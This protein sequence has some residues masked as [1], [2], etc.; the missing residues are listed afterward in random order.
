[1]DTISDD[2]YDTVARFTCFCFLIGSIQVS[3]YCAEWIKA[4][5]ITK[6]WRKISTVL[7]ITAKYVLFHDL[8]NLLPIVAFLSDLYEKNSEPTS[9]YYKICQRFGRITKLTIK[10]GFGFYIAGTTLTFIPSILEA[11]IMGVY[12]PPMVI[13][14]PRILDCFSTGI[15]V[16]LFIFNLI[17]AAVVS[18]TICPGDV[19]FFVMFANVPMITLI[20]RGHLEGLTVALEQKKVNVGVIKHRMAQYI[21]MQRRYNEW[22]GI[23]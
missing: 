12:M 13:Y 6:F 9:Q 8:Q 5:R 7:Q 20:I 4:T 18:I 23:K 14:C 3:D 15:T 11:I 21:R 1:M 19:M 17:M 22:V 10:V 2:H 16:S